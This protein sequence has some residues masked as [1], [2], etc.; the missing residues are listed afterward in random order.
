MISVIFFRSLYFLQS[1][2]SPA[3]E[4][5]VCALLSGLPNEVD[6][7]INTIVEM[8]IEC[9]P[10][11]QHYSITIPLLDFRKYPLLIDLLLAHIGIFSSGLV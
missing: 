2:I 5:I 4:R 11:G 7:A 8:A 6:F 9:S 10:N 1:P 3:Y